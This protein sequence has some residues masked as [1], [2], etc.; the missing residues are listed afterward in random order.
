MKG[1]PFFFVCYIYSTHPLSLP[2]KYFK[3]NHRHH[4][5]LPVNIKYFQQ[6]RTLKNGHSDYGH[7]HQ[8]QQLL[9]DIMGHPGY[10]QYFPNLS[11]KC[12]FIIL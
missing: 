11:Q 3:A 1:C 7:I 6:I 8:D 10:N 4:I 12:Y 5:H 9:H 2:L